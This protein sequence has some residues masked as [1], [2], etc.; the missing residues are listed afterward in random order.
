MRSSSL[1][2]RP[3]LLLFSVFVL[4][5]ALILVNGYALS[6]VGLLPNATVVFILFSVEFLLLAGWVLRQPLWIVG[7][8][9]ELAGFLF[10]VVVTFLYFISPSWPTLIPP[11]YSGDAA[12]HYLYIDKTFS[13]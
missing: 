5:F 4:A 2:V 9:L 13:S 11:S 3:A 12:I 7:E 10:V 6:F 1:S 8:P